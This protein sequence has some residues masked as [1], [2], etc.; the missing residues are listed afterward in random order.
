[1]FGQVIDVYMDSIGQTIPEYLVNFDFF[2]KVMNDNGFKPVVPPSVNRKYSSIFKKDNFDNKN[3]GEFKNIINKIPEIEK[4]DND[5]NGKY[6]P[7]KDMYNTYSKN[8]IKTLSS[9]N[10]YFVFQKRE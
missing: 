10:N 3:I 2:V 5:F 7:A 1:M 6:S 9:F 4:T 8:P